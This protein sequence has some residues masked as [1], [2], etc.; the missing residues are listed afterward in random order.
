MKSDKL[1][2]I[3]I[4]IAL[5][6]FLIP[7]FVKASPVIIDDTP[8][9][10]NLKTFII[11][12]KANIKFI[13][14]YEDPVYFNDNLYGKFKQNEEIFYPDNTNI[15]IGIPSKI[16]TDTSNIWETFV[17]P[18]SVNIIGFPL[19]Y[20]ILIIIVIYFIYWILNKRRY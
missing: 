10:Q 13:N 18:L 17:K 9:A 2:L 16:T 11:E 7:S 20:G 12:D 14:E 3:L 15:T 8:D 19:T 4:I 6:L 1:K 5:T